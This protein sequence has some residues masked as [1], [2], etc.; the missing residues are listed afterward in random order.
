MSVPDARFNQWS[1]VSGVSPMSDFCLV[2]GSTQ[3]PHGWDRLVRELELLGHE[4]LCADLPVNQPNAS[5]TEYA[6]II[7]TALRDMSQP[8]VVAHSA[9]GLFL[10]L[11]VDFAPVRQL[12]YLAAVL[13]EPGMSFL[14]QFR[15]SPAM[16]KA[17]FVGK[18]PTKN[19]SL[20]LHYLF[21]DCSSE[22]AQWAFST[23][24]LSFAKQA[25]VEK[26]PLT[27]WPQ[28]PVSYISCS[29]ERVLEPAWWEAAAR[30]R[31]QTEPVLIESG[32]APH[33]SRPADLARILDHIARS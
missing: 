11:V 20:A 27:E 21:H 10:P 24:R 4:C 16:Y 15:T 31:L 28:I 33:V 3:G 14:E 9:S 8:I 26:T 5:A 2:H 7:G 13:P 23:L 18:D 17:D 12:V 32:H 30:S 29:N 22:V 6:A 25:L 1:F 19:D